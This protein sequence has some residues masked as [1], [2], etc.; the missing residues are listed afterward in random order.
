MSMTSSSDGEPRLIVHS[1]GDPERFR[2]CNFVTNDRLICQIGGMVNVEGILIPFSRLISMDLDGR[3]LTRL[4][5]AAPLTM[6]R[7]RQFDGSVLD[8]SGGE[9]GSIL[10]ARESCPRQGGA[11]TRLVPRRR[12]SRGRS[13]RRPDAAHATGGT[14]QSRAER[15]ISDGRGNV[16][17]MATLERRST[18]QIGTRIT[19][20]YRT[21]AQPGLAPVLD[22]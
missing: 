5:Q 11:G 19:Y 3:N 1:D 16:R 13:D 10:M 21:A 22:L 17:I 2:W 4:G 8:W 12:R 9:A 15:Y 18:G 14:A 20:L 7:M 6:R